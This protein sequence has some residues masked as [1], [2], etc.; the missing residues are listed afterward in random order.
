MRM[1]LPSSAAIALGGLRLNVSIGTS[2]M[3]APLNLSLIHILDEAELPGAN[4]VNFEVLDEALNRLALQD[5]QQARVVELRFFGGL[6]IEETA[7]Q[8]Q[9]SYATVKRDWVVARAWLLRELSE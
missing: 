9:I 4:G 7:A 3:V 1:N 5:P 8:L 6:S 2:W